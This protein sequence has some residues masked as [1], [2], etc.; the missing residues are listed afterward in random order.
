MAWLVLITYQTQ[1][2]KKVLK[3][4]PEGHIQ[5]CQVPSLR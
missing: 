2:A 3:L 4:Q 5:F 1:A